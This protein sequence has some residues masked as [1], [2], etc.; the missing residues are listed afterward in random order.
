MYGAV[1]ALKGHLEHINTV[2][3]RDG[4]HLPSDGLGALL[5]WMVKIQSRQSMEFRMR[6][7]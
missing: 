5:T 2:Y 4:I 1:R 3:M 6:F 7:I